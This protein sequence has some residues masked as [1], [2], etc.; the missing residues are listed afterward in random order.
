M[1]DFNTA[2]RI[3]N[4]KIVIHETCQYDDK[5]ICDTL[6]QNDILFFDDCLYS[7]YVFLRKN[8]IAL[9]QKNV[10]CVL[11]LS[12]SICRKDN[13]QPTYFAHCAE[14]HDKVH[15]NDV[16]AYAAYMSIDEVKQLLRFSNVLVACHGDNHLELCKVKSK[17]D[18][19][20]LFQKDIIAAS[21]MLKHLDMKTDIF[22]YPYAFDDIML[23]RHT[24]KQ[25]GYRHIFAG[26][27][28]KRIPFET[29]V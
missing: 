13:L 29:L 15:A 5:Q 25:L 18:R 2:L 20:V 24:L 3:C 1:N 23:S 21:D 7:Q 4:R 6:Q 10:T 9:Q 17:I 19:A 28:S 12:T 8:I 16:S 26:N 22:V 14:C 27:D 11:G